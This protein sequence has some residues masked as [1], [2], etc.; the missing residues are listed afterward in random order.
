MF[1][2]EMRKITIK[3]KDGTIRTF[4]EKGRA[5]GSYTIS[6]QYKGAFAIVEDEWGNTVSFPAEEIAEIQTEAGRSF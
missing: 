5:G 2:L 1:G 3:L 6:I 4:E